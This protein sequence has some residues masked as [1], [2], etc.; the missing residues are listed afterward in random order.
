MYP[1]I[2]INISNEREVRNMKEIR[3]MNIEELSQHFGSEIITQEQMNELL[4]NDYVLHIDKHDYDNGYDCCMV[5]GHFFDFE[6]ID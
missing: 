5:A 1:C 3:E 4:K 6:V 2:I